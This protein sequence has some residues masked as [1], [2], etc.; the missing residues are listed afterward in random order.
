MSGYK[1]G[2]LRINCNHNMIIGINS[3]ITTINGKRCKV[4]PYLGGC[5]HANN[6]SAFFMHIP[7]WNPYNTY[8][9]TASSRK[10]DT[11]YATSNGDVEYYMYNG[12]LFDSNCRMYL[13]PVIVKQFDEKGNT[14]MNN[15]LVVSDSIFKKVDTKIKGFINKAIYEVSSYRQGNYDVHVVDSGKMMIYVPYGIGYNYGLSSAFESSFTNAR[16]FDTMRNGHYYIDEIER[17]FNAK[18]IDNVNNVIRLRKDDQ[19]KLLC[20]EKTD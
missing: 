19:N 20:I 16:I 17:T 10:C 6:S 18:S 3:I 5:V 7:A 12:F 8:K 9:L 1:A 14:P 11:I 13:M 15:A 4:L 2:E